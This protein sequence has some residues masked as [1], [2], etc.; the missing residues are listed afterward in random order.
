MR[1]EVEAATNRSY[2]KTSVVGIIGQVVAADDIEMTELPSPFV[3]VIF[4]VV[5]LGGV[6]LLTAS[7]GN[8]MDEGECGR[9]FIFLACQRFQVRAQPSFSL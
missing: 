2:E 1:G 3:P 7:L 6:G 5:L 4:G 9:F 8:V